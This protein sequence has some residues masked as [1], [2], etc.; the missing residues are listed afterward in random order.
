MPKELTNIEVVIENA[1]L[2]NKLNIKLWE[3]LLS[4]TNKSRII[5]FKTEDTFGGKKIPLVLIQ[6]HF[7]NAI[8]TWM[9][10]N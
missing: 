5:Y 7:L 4:T 2:N 10:K 9:W 1:I 8:L 3:F 6:N